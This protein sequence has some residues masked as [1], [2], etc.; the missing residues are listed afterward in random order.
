MKKSKKSTRFRASHRDIPRVDQFAQAFAQGHLN[1]LLLFGGAGVGKSQSLRRAVGA[2]GC[3]IA[4]HA[5]P[6]GIYL[7]AYEHRGKPLIL[8][9]VDGLYRDRNGVRLLKALGQTDPVKTV[10]WTSDAAGLDRRGVPR[11]FETT[12]RVAIVGNVWQVS[13]SGRGRLGDRG[14]V[15][16]FKPTPL[17]VHLHAATWFWD[18][19][20]FDFVADHLHLIGSPS[21]RNPRGAGRSSF[22]PQVWIGRRWC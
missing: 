3:F 11:K 21:L 9:D 22:A 20:A 19:E 7:A 5:S 2:A 12:S 8:D 15:V 10:A 14:H 18:Q 17:E 1:L 13:Q 4:G 6:F 16:H